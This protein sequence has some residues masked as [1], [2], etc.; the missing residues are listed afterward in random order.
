[1]T[2]PE[3]TFRADIVRVVTEPRRGLSRDEAARYVGIGTTLFDEMVLKK[4][5]PGPF[6]IGTRVLWDIH[7]LDAALDNIVEAA[8]GNPWDSVA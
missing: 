7:K 5:M 8:A 2:K 6:R 3:P 1:M 4:Q